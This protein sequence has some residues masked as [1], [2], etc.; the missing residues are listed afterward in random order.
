[1][2]DLS[3]SS[4]LPVSWDRSSERIYFSDE[5]VDIKPDVRRRDEMLEVLFNPL[6]DDIDELYYMYRGVARMEDQE[7]INR[8]GLRYDITAIKPGVLG[9][10]Y[11]KTAGHYH[12]LAG[13]VLLIR[14]YMRSFMAVPIIFCSSLQARI[15]IG[16]A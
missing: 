15:R 3:R 6:A 13:P 9:D 7:E 8:R 14:K 12:P 10:E 5:L 2:I 11:V 4:G 16:S 1:M